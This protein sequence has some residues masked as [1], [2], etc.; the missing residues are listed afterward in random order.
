M[1]DSGGPGLHLE[2]T[3]DLPP[4]AGWSDGA[5]VWKAWPGTE[6]SRSRAPRGAPSLIAKG[7]RHASQACRGGSQ[8]P[9]G[10]RK[11]PRFSALRSP[12]LGSV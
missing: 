3:T 2:V 6:K 12:H 5:A 8:P 1:P 7:R 4:G 10:P 9:R 11:P